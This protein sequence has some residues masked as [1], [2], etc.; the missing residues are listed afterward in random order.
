[1][2]AQKKRNRSR[3]KTKKSRGSEVNDA[4]CGPYSRNDVISYAIEEEMRDAWLSVLIHGC[5]RHSFDF[6][7]FRRRPPHLM[8]ALAR[9]LEA[10]A[11]TTEEKM[12]KRTKNQES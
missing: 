3:Q 7:L 1:M 10:L 9:E 6:D 8:F 4:G 2:I 11:T 5:S 12:Q